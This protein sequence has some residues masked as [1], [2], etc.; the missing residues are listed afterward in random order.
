MIPSVGETAAG[1]TAA[2]RFGRFDA[3]AAELLKEDPGSAL[4]SFWV[5][6]PV[7]PIFLY[8]D[9]VQG[10]PEMASGGVW[11]IVMAIAFIVDWCAYLLAISHI[12]DQTGHGGR[13]LRYVAA[14]NWSRLYAN[15]VMLAALSLE[16]ALGQSLFGPIV[17]AATIYLLIFQGFV[18][19]AVLGFSGMGAAGAVLLSVLI[20]FITQV[21]AIGVLQ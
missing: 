20:G 8:F 2:I 7:F 1:F 19:K 4:R 17:F 10:V 3:R 13:L 12:A 11:V 15:F 5:M 6:A 18:V 14:H 16:M 21:T 9:L